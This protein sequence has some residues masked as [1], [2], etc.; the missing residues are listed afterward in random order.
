MAVRKGKKEVIVEP[1]VRAQLSVL[2]RIVLAWENYA[3]FNNLVPSQKKYKE[4]QLT[5]MLDLSEKMGQQFPYEI[6]ECIQDN[7]D[8]ATLLRKPKGE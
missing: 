7:K 4:A 5:Y 1:V 8:V 6:I 3:A 2:Q